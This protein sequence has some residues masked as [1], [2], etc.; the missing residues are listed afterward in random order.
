M[1]GL[2]DAF[3]NATLFAV[4][5][6][7]AMLAK[8]SQKMQAKKRTVET[9]CCDAAALAL[10]WSF[11]VVASSMCLQ[12]MMN[13]AATFAHWRAQLAPEGLM[14]VALPVEGTFPEWTAL[15]EDI[16]VPSRLR[17]LP[18]VDFLRDPSVAERVERYYQDYE[19]G[20]A[21]ATHLKETGAS[22][23]ANVPELTFVQKQA[24]IAKLK[25]QRPF[26]VTWTILS[27]TTGPL[28]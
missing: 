18:A 15:C 3:P 2:A 13:P 17:S 16:G 26:S 7:S 27:L 11:D 28:L 8:A 6:S 10:D 23:A 14:V 12:W 20:L 22:A 19:T 1:E 24:L 4:D 25:Q 5:Q 21:F 9:I